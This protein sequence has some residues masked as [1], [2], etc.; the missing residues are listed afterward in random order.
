M[1]LNFPIGGCPTKKTP[2]KTIQKTKS[3]NTQKP[4]TKQKQPNQPQKQ[5]THQHTKKKTTL[6][7]GVIFVGQPPN[8]KSNVILFFCHQHE[9]FLDNIV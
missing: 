3:N 8:G 1:T 2:R 4:K 5:K 7:Q 9:L 6:S